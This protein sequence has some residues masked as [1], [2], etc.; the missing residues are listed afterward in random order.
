[1][2]K[3]SMSKLALKRLAD[4]WPL[5]LAIFTGIILATTLVAGA[6]VYV[7]ALERLALNKAIDGLN[8]PFSS[9]TAY[10]LHVPLTSDRLRSTEQA[11][12]NAIESNIAEI[13]EGRERYLIV[14]TYLARVPANP[15]PSAGALGQVS[16]AYFRYFSNLEHHVTFVDGHMATTA[17]SDTTRG[18]VLEA[19]ISVVS[20]ETFGLKVGDT[21]ELRP[22]PED[23]VRVSATIVGI[24]EATNPTEDYWQLQASFFLDPPP[25]EEPI[26]GPEATAES[27]LNSA[28]DRSGIGEARGMEM[29][30]FWQPSEESPAAGELTT[31]MS[32]AEEEIDFD[33]EE[34]PLPLF[35]TQEAMVEAVGE[36]YRGTLIESIWFIFVD[37]ERL[38]DWSISEVRQRLW[39]LEDDLRVSTPGSEITTGIFRMLKKFETRS[40]FS[41]LPLLLLITIMVAILLFYLSMVVSYLVQSREADLALLRSRGV[42]TSQLVRLYGLEGVLLT[43]VAVVA[44]PFLAMGAVALAGK[45]PFFTD[46]TGGGT[47]PVELTPVPFLAALGIG[48]VCLL[49]FMTLGL[50]GARGGL[51][52]HKMRTSRPPTTPLFQRYYIDVALLAL[53]GLLFWELHSR[54]QIVSGGLFKDVEVNETLLLAPILFL[55]AIALVFLRVFPLF[56]RFAS[57]ESQALVH[58]LTAATLLVLAP[59]LAVRGII[60]GNVTAWVGP[61]A[62]LLVL[63]AI[64]WGTARAER[65]RYRV[66]GIILQIAPV[67]AFLALEP[68]SPGDVLFIPTIGLIGVVPAQIASLLFKASTRSAPAWLS[69]GLWRMARNPM[70]YTWLV[71][72]LL[73]AT[74]LGILSTTVGGTLDRSQRERILYEVAADVRVTD[75]PNLGAL[76]EQMLR[77]TYS[78]IPGVTLVS[79]AR[80]DGGSVGPTTMQVLA[81]DSLNFPYV[82][83]YRDDFSDQPL[84]SV[85][86]ALSQHP[87][88]KPLTISPGATEVGLWVKPLEEY[89]NINVWLVVEDSTA[90]IALLSAGAVGSSEWHLLRADVPS[91]LM[92]PL[93]LV[94]VQISEP[95]FGSNRTAGNLLLDDIH[96]VAGPQNG[97]YLLEDFEGLPRWMPIST[98]FLS[99]DRIT[100]TGDEAY[101]GKK[102]GLFSFGSNTVAGM[103]GFYQSPTGGA[104]PVVAS[105]SFMEATG[106]RVGFRLTARIGGRL[107]PI[108]VRDTVDF[109]PTMSPIGGGFLLADLNDLMSHLRILSPLATVAPNELF[110]S[111]VP[112]ASDEVLQS[113]N[114]LTQM[115]GEVRDRDSL[116]ESMRVDPLT[117]PSWKATV[118]VALGI[119]LIAAGLGY[120]TYLLAVAGRSSDEMGFLQSVGFSRFQVIGLLA[121]EHLAVAAVG[122][123]LGTWAGLL[124][125][126]LMVSS[127]A[128]TERG[129]QVLPPFV[130]MI[131]WSL[132][133]PVY[134]ALV[135]VFL[136][137][138][139]ALHRAI[140]R[141]SIQAL[142][143]V[144]GL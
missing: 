121:F 34:P 24:V 89:S 75:I 84:D 78:T 71:V 47:L 25:L 3:L 53:G 111:G 48:L 85:M 55:I 6:P 97:E 69:M 76:S 39:G 56:V 114:I 116:L 18:P 15:L 46:I 100:Q 29:F 122:L 118:I 129:E 83:W 30:G 70:Q 22:S 123:G 79:L 104:I 66:A 92:P 8:R 68:L 86:N 119:V 82:S 59:G 101:H 98:D 106:A 117:S 127:V 137:A 133:L 90:A 62:L 41:R 44:A 130:L 73:L 144:E 107:I 20:A 87:Q 12:E 134:A 72:L 51:V 139:F 60:D 37:T 21:V 50:L 80:R 128:V 36:T 142:S 96:V 54:G 49:L 63:A 135:A 2:Q 11:L 61:V 131:D 103:R 91:R 77:D 10:A 88:V 136:A 126:R 45:L 93:R 65:L 132:M 138:L 17:I 124:V 109:F 143:R 108:V 105:S 125:S 99:S 31:P 94:S 7:R 23:T 43:M 35:I 33:T 140:A 9:I 64:Y 4:D 112:A 113:V 38:K 141:V 74:G 1:M 52:L 5:L 110:L 32:R 40:F 16:R 58:L 19:I 57:G 115:Y 27:Y 14:R 67:A 28:A 95:G 13:Y 102:S 42:G 26:D 81:V 120:V